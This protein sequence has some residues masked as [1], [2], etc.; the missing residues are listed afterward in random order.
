MKAARFDKPQEM[1]KDREDWCVAWSIYHKSFGHDLTAEQQHSAC[2]AIE[3]KHWYAISLS[4]STVIVQLW[5]A[6][7]FVD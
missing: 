5:S 2:I 3:L 4:Q 7:L 1:M 6:P